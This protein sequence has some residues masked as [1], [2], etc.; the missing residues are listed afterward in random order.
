MMFVVS[1]V[2]V[3]E[4]LRGLFL[5]KTLTTSLRKRTMKMRMKMFLLERAL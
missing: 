4:S 5:M 2:V 1:V 3:V